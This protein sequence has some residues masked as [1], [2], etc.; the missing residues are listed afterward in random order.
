MQG[1]LASYLLGFEVVSNDKR[2][3]FK[4]K[5]N[6]GLIKLIF[7][8]LLT[9]GNFNIY[10]EYKITSVVK[11]NK[12]LNSVNDGDVANR[13]IDLPNSY[14]LYNSD[15]GDRF[16][17]VT[18]TQSKHS[19][20]VVRKLYTVSIIDDMY[21]C[22]KDQEIKG[23]DKRAEREGYRYSLWS[24]KH[25]Y[26]MYADNSMEIV[27]VSF[28]EKSNNGRPFILLKSRYEADSEMLST[29]KYAYDGYKYQMMQA[30]ELHMR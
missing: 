4:V 19:D 29:W 2:K 1:A 13:I 10:G 3:I 15:T 28:L 9:I 5:N 11:E 20:D 25:A 24:T 17:V 27:A 23:A 12:I 26:D 18:S 30:H 6:N 21:D 7:L 8:F 22:E 14:E 16:Y